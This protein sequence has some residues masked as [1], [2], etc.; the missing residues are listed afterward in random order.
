MKRQRSRSWRGRVSL[1]GPSS[2]WIP[3]VI[4][5]LGVATLLLALLVQQGES[6]PG[7]TGPEVGQTPATPQDAVMARAAL[8]EL[9]QLDFKGPEQTPSDT[10]ARDIE[11]SVTFRHEE[12]S[13]LRM[14]G[15]WDGD[16]A[17]GSTGNVFRV[18]FTPTL[19]GRW[20]LADVAS[21]DPQLDDQHE[22]RVVMVEDRMANAGFW[23]SNDD[24]ASGR[25]FQRSDGSH[26][27]ILGNTHYTFLSEMA[28]A[29]V[30]GND[31][32]SDV[33]GN[34]RYFNKLRFSVANAWNPDPN[35]ASF[36]DD[37][38]QPTNDG[39][40]S[41][42][43]NPSW[44]HDRTDRA[45]AAA[46]ERDL[47]A[48]LILVPPTDGAARRAL[49][50]D[51]AEVYLRYVAA[52]YGAFPNVWIT[53]GNE[54]IRLPER[55]VEVGYSVDEV[56]DLGQR[57]Q[58]WLPYPTPVSKHDPG[59]WDPEL[60]TDPQWFDHVTVFAKRRTLPEAA[61]F[62]RRN[63]RVVSDAPVINDEQSY[64]G[65]GDDHTTTDTIAAH[66]GAFVGGG[67][68]TTG[69]KSEY[70]ESQYFWGGFDP[71]E[72]QSAEHL[73]W[74][75]TAIDD[76]VRFWRLESTEVNV[77]FDQADDGWRALASEAG[78]E[79]VLGTNSRRTDVRARLGAG[80]WQVT[81]LDPIAMASTELDRE[82]SGE[83][84]F[85]TP[86]SS[87]ALFHFRRTR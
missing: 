8:Y 46:Y 76:R 85:D 47:I 30:G 11:L 27:Y 6:P 7:D 9:V 72:H 58:R 19:P 53:L 69:Y 13:D 4:G 64:E 44:F 51:N 59:R 86:E 2:K 60:I 29:E 40:W 1:E 14:L 80:Q 17:G 54:I 81:L 65:A 36:F 49:K 22:G 48:D 83:F 12:G 18:R 37:D 16:G 57:L 43:P 34:A 70:K 45:V 71:A 56:I 5:L 23:I 79:Y 24:A 25:W 77:A 61:D 21:N 41:H 39:T 84:R 55:G 33:R 52:R 35:V 68:G 28:G 62:I 82:A 32:V 20:R 31:I 3:V 10:P 75:R 66:V 15:F 73:R 78:D 42:R 63:H 74:L 67:Y 50:G 26:P 38:G 87:A